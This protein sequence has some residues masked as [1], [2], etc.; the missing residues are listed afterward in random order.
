M[1]FDVRTAW[2]RLASLIAALQP[3]YPE[4]LY[5]PA[6]DE[7]RVRFADVLGRSLPDELD[8]LYALHDGEGA[9]GSFAFETADWDGSLGAYVFLPLAGE[10]DSV[11]A[12]WTDLRAQ[13]RIPEHFVPFGKDAAGNAL[14]VDDAPSK[15]GVTGQIVEVFTDGTQTRLVEPTLVDYLDAMA[16]QLEGLDAET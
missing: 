5:P 2:E 7:A 12:A 4:N 3:D 11:V 13:G 14:C 16:R 9:L 15:G 10:T 8:A 1:S 6:T